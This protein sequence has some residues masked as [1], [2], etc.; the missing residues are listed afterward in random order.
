MIKDTRLIV[1]PDG[2]RFFKEVNDAIASIQ[3]RGLY[4]EVNYSTSSAIGFSAMII[5]REIK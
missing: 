3:K 5:G 4:A 1:N 2:T